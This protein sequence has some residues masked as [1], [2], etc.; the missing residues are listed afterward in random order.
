[1][2]QEA[3]LP[4]LEKSW[5]QMLKLTPILK[6]GLVDMGNAIGDL[7]IKGAEMM[8]S[9]PWRKDLRTISDNNVKAFE[10]FGQA[11]LNLADAFR[12]IMVVAGPLVVKMGQFTE[13]IT[14]AFRYWAAQKRSSGE[15]ERWFEEMGDRLIELITIIGRYAKAVWDITQVLA[16]V[17]REVLK[18]VLAVAELIANFAQAHPNLFK[19]IAGA[20][21]LVSAF[22]ALCPG[23]DRVS[24]A[25]R[26]AIDC[27]RCIGSRISAA[28]QTTVGFAQRT[29]GAGTAATTAGGQTAAAGQRMGILRTGFQQGSVAAQQFITRMQTTPGVMSRVATS[30]SPVVRAVGGAK[31]A[32]A[33]LGTAMGNV[34]RA[35]GT[36]LRT[37][38]SGLLGVLGG[39]WGLA[40]TAG[41][42]LL[43]LF[44]FNSAEAEQEQAQ[45]KQSA[46]GVADV[47]REQNFQINENVRAALLK[48]AADEGILTA[49]RDAGVPTQEL[50]DALLGTSDALEVVNRKFDVYIGKHQQ[51]GTVSTPTGQSVKRTTGAL[52]EQGTAA[53]GAKDKL[54]GLSGANQQA[55]QTEPEKEDA[56]TEATGRTGTE[57]EASRRAT[58]ASWSKIDADMALRGAALSRSEAQTQLERAQQ[59]LIELEKDG[60]KGTLEWREAMNQYR[61]A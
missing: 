52:D 27:F 7:A 45:L 48:Q 4:K 50:T 57:A 25:I 8:T 32:L 26:V 55:A 33:S 43:S 44:A 23:I 1:A 42:G 37:A 56:S 41:I 58:D 54:N 9:G 49:A 16:P 31:G 24:G 14:A 61:R 17:G 10:H 40:I 21:N 15:M 18:L 22:V 6:D 60:K 39:P 2:V 19:I 29:V 59:R 38:F 13:A 11:G 51:V 36:R 35:A 5:R 20:R 30:F 28:A 3:M 53:Q 12:H 47:L 46:K 34:A